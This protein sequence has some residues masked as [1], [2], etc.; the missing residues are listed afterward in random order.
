[1]KIH[2]SAFLITALLTL[3]ACGGT[4]SEEQNFTTAPPT[5]VIVNDEK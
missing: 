3:T 2:T 4:E 1:M 5:M